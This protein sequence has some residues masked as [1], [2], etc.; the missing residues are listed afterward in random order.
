[1]SVFSLFD[2]FIEQ[3]TGDNDGNDDGKGEDYNNNI[4]N[5]SSSEGQAFLW[6][7]LAHLC[8]IYWDGTFMR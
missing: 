7:S 5:H 8:Q 1:M 2:R 4:W 6:R 3:Y